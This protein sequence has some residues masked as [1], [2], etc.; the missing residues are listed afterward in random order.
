M[1]EVTL[2]AQEHQDLPYEKLVEELRYE[3]KTDDLTLFRAYFNLLNFEDQLRLP[4]LEASYLAME[5]VPVKFD[6]QLSVTDTGR[7]LTGLLGYN[8]ALF[9]AAQIE[10]LGRQF[11]TLLENVVADPGQKIATVLRSSREQQA[12]VINDFNDDFEI[13]IGV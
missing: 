10:S 6:L 9:D 11:I 4:G 7:E 12:Q 1:R 5:S 8:S 13:S 2:D 3:R